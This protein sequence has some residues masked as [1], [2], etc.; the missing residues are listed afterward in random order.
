[1]DKNLRIDEDEYTKDEREASLKLTEEEIELAEQSIQSFLESLS[2]ENDDEPA[3]DVS[4]PEPLPIE[5][6]D[7]PQLPDLLE[8]PF[9]PE[10]IV[11]SE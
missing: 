2:E 8:V 6:L 3:F 7:F 4:S 5:E 10:L 9:S 1:M 11:S